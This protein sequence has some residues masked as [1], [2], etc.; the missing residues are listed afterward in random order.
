[1]ATRTPSNAPLGADDRS[2]TADE[3]EPRSDRLPNRLR[4]AFL[5]AALTQLLMGF[6]N[7]ATNIAFPSIEIA[8]ASTPRTTLAWA[9]TGFGIVQ[10]SMLLIC[11]YAADRLG[12]KVIFLRGILVFGAGSLL[13][14][15][16]PTAAVFLLARLVQAVGASLILPSGLALLLLEFPASRRIW[17]TSISAGLMSVGQATSPLLGAV[18]VEWFGWRSVYFWPAVLCVPLIL[19]GRRVFRESEIV[20]REH[21]VDILGAGI[22]AVSLAALA[23]SLSQ[24]SRLGWT[25][26]SVLA[27]LAAFGLL[28]PI[29]VL[30][31]THHAEPLFDPHLLKER[32][33]AGAGAI[34]F[35]VSAILLG[36][37]FA[38]PLL[39]MQGFDYS[40]F[41]A[42]VVLT[43]VP[44]VMAV[45]ALIA[46]RSIERVGAKTVVVIG[47]LTWTVSM[48]IMVWM[49]GAAEP[50][51][52]LIYVPFVLSGVGFGLT[53]GPLQGLAL[54]ETDP[55][56]FGQVNAFYWTV[57][58]A[59][60]SLGVALV[61]GL[62][63]DAQPIPVPK[64][65]DLHLALAVA[66]IVALA[67]ALTLLPGGARQ[68]RRAQVQPETVETS[69]AN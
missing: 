62:L 1:M 49:L 64:F 22:C 5:L 54:S 43:P 11:G 2:A 44:A 55:S 32:S 38:W 39:L 19:A 68:R 15:V 36:A 60:N 29:L 10:A 52:L 17:V 56:K 31:S 8:F 65:R 28:T 58:M 53:S 59:G 47:L 46:S 24:G 13:A 69:H 33:V 67:M 6:T 3:S 7:T 30:R 14:S 42:G 45:A 57:R 12:R 40:A 20:P 66:S 63:G 27:G 34:A 9:V 51:G 48:W 4:V 50:N 21:R 16:A 37:W 41:H 35:M 61:I 25:S 23:Y 18:L 26:G